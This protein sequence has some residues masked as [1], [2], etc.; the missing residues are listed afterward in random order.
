MAPA[1]FSSQD[2]EQEKHPTTGR[3]NDVAAGFIETDNSIYVIPNNIGT[4]NS[5]LVNL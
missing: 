3:M 2:H 4:E 5:E 1:P